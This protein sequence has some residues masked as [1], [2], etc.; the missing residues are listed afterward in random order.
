MGGRQPASIASAK[1]ELSGQTKRRITTLRQ[2]RSINGAYP[3]HM[4]AEN[5]AACLT[6]HALCTTG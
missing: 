3:A 6:L 1:F 5:N 2:S 4:D